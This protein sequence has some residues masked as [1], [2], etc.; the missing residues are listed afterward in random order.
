MGRKEDE[1]VVAGDA[2]LDAKLEIFRQVQSS[3]ME[4]LKLIEKYQDDICA[5]S[6][7]E[8]AMGRFLKQMSSIDKTRAGKMMSAVGKAQ[9]NSSDQRIALRGPLVRLYQEIETFRYR[10]ISDTLMTINR[11][12]GARLEYRAALMWMKDISK[13]LDPDTYKQLEKFRKVQTQVRTTKL[14]FDKLKNDVCQKV[15]LLGASRC[16]LLSHTLANYQNV[17]LHYLDKSSRTLSAVQESFKGYQHYEFNMLKE[18][19]ETSKQLARLTGAKDIL[20]DLD[21]EVEK[22]HQERK[23]EASSQ[24][25]QESRVENNGTQDEDDDQ[26]IDLKDVSKKLAAETGGDSGETEQGQEVHEGDGGDETARRRL[27]SLG[28]DSN[29]QGQPSQAQGDGLGPAAN[30]HQM[31]GGA[32]K[33]LELSEADK[34]QSAFIGMMANSGE[35]GNDPIT[36]KYAD[37][38]LLT[39]EPLEQVPS[40][41]NEELDLLNEILNMPSTVPE[42]PM[43]YSSFFEGMDQAAGSSDGGMDLSAQRYLP[44]DLLD[45]SS[46]MERMPVPSA[47]DP[48]G[49]SVLQPQQMPGATEVEQMALHMA[50][51]KEQ[52]PVKKNMM[53]SSKP[54][55][56]SKDGKADMTAWFN[57][58]ADLDPLQNP[59]TVGQQEGEEVEDRN[60]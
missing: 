57:L 49:G 22:L 34:E 39:E 4:M 48:S 3:C 51:S 30:S 15:D 42:E 32:I 9:T 14:R 35:Q 41:R 55:A 40:N 28:E 13:E 24:R 38:D 26:L 21:E 27:I 60:C 1:F 47:G 19:S 50:S 53:D 10:A 44:S 23:K 45:V 11:M 29:Q 46:M 37:I 17:L 33:S 56:F 2:E 31:A 18:L 12:E 36:D 52:Q 59:D 54:Q 43:D 7:E 25:R 20:P 16:N 58:F 6:Q 8:N 5:L